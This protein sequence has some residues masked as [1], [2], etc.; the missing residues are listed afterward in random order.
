MARNGR[1]E[2]KDE[3][4]RRRR[5]RGVALLV[6]LTVVVMFTAFVAD[7][8]YNARMRYTMASHARD[9]AKAEA[10]AVSGVRIYQLLLLFGDAAQGRLSAFIPA[11]FKGFLGSGSMVVR[12]LPGG[13]VDTGLLRLLGG[14]SM[15]FG[16]SDEEMVQAEMESQGGMSGTSRSGDHR[17]PTR[18]GE[19]APVESGSF[20]DFE[21][22]FITCAKEE[23]TKISL[24]GIV[25]TGLQGEMAQ[26]LFQTLSRE[27]YEPL[28]REANIMPEELISNLIDW[29]D[30]DSERANGRGYEDS[31]YNNLEDPYTA[32]N[33]PYDTLAEMHLVAGMTDEIYDVLA[34]LVT[35]NT[36][37]D[38]IYLPLSGPEMLGALLATVLPK[39][40]FTQDDIQRYWRDYQ[41]A[42]MGLPIDNVEILATILSS[43]QGLQAL[44]V[45][46][47]KKVV[48]TNNKKR[49]KVFTLTS[50][51]R[52]GDVE[53]TVEVVVDISKNAHLGG[54]LVYWRQE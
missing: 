18:G 37:A 35:V 6:V 41:V 15:A 31:L 34:P 13:C 4:S 3:L 29:G 27:Q 51:G 9:A 32:K 33:A 47:M 2:T 40:R 16:L 36:V 5:E 10:L 1:G 44:D 54:L 17:G 38:K 11:Q 39:H 50:T 53:R 28:F 21:G 43:L 20:L 23:S 46:E 52:V 7:F 8:S 26:L 19:F 30:I 14:S 48:A 12:L 42:S 25:K 49:P 45:A 24:N 22:D